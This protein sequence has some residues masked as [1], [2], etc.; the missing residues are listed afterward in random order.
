MSGRFSAAW[1]LHLLSSI[2]LISAVMASL[3]VGVLV[4]HAVCVSM[5]KLF[6]MH[7]TQVAARSAKPVATPARLGVIGN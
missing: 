4:A 6:H 1:G 7:A 2:L 3:A 5:F